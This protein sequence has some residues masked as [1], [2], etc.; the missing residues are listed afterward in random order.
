M[1]A[2]ST[3]VFRQFVGQPK[4]AGGQPSVDD[5]SLVME[6]LSRQRCPGRV[7]ARFERISATKRCSGVLEIPKRGFPRERINCKMKA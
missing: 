1:L 6:K 2:Y 5:Q 4:K 3:Q 7:L